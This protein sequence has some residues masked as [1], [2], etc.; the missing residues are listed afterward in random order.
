MSTPTEMYNF[1]EVACS[2]KTITMFQKCR[3]ISHFKEK[4]SNLLH[5]LLLAVHF[6]FYSRRSTIMALIR[7]SEIQTEVANESM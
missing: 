3:V 4:I 7:T 6:N 2:C 5:T 1:R